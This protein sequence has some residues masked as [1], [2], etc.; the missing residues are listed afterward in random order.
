MQPASFAPSRFRDALARSPSLIAALAIAA[1]GIVGAATAFGPLYVLAGLLTLLAGLAILVSTEAGLIA[2][3]ALITL[4]PFGTLPFKAIVTPNFL[5]LALVSLSVVWSLRLLVRSDAY[6]LRLTRFGLPVLGF[7]GLTFFSLVLGAGGLPDTLTLHNY[8]KFVLG[9]LFFFSVVNCVLTRSQAR[10]IMRGLLLS[11]ALA[12]LI[13]L[14]LLALPD[15]LALNMLVTLGRIGYPTEERVL[16][17]IED[18][19][20]TGLERAIGLSVDPNSFAG[21]LA[22]VTALALALLFARRSLLPR[23]IL[24]G[25]VGVLTLA[26]LLTFSRGALLG[27]LAAAIYLAILRYRRIWW[28]MIGAGVL[29]GGL[30]F[31]L[32]LGDDIIQRLFAGV[33]MQDQAQQMR[34]DEYQNAIAIIA[35]YPV[36]G[37]GFGQAPDIDLTAGVSSIYLAIAQRMG[38][39][40]LVAF[41]SLVATWFTTTFRATRHLDEERADWL[42]GIQAGLVAALV[43]G[44]ADHYFF[45]IEFSH[46]VALFWGAAGLGMAI[47]ALPDAGR[48]DDLKGSLV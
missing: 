33:Q 13:A 29:G 22:L 11:G 5:E 15:T 3:F 17:Y 7:L 43:V 8:A 40:G 41:V 28:V 36:F 31:A 21:M 45:N 47:I 30:M 23:G 39:V 14:L 46:M 10:L 20:G 12:A 16:R 9:V 18:G 35:R 42:L 38:L 32:G 4:L 24:S 25:V 34:L 44:V 1:G 19:P 2:S 26:L 27:L 6:D 48:E 37:I